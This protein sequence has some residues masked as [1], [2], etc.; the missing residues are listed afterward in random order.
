MKIIPVLLFFVVGAL[1]LRPGVALGQTPAPGAYPVPCDI[2]VTYKASWYY[3][4]VRGWGM[5]SDGKLVPT[6]LFFVPS[7]SEEY[8]IRLARARLVEMI[9]AGICRK[10]AL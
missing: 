6:V 3:G 1:G 10:P 7:G 2:N 5:S 4:Q 8:A 9:N